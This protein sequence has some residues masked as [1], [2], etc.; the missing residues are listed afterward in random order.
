M[1][2]YHVAEY[3]YYGMTV[4]NRSRLAIVGMYVDTDVSTVCLW[5]RK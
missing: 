5:T 3:V 1:Y 2:E 4:Q